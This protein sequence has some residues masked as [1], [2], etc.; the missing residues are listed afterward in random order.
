[1]KTVWKAEERSVKNFHCSEEGREAAALAEAASEGWEDR[2]WA[3]DRGGL[4]DRAHYAQRMWQAN[5]GLMKSGW[6]KRP[7]G[8]GENACGPVT[9]L[10]WGEK[11]SGKL[12]ISL[13]SLLELVLKVAK[14]CHCEEP[15][16][17][18][19][20]PRGWKTRAKIASRSLSWA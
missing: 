8:W 4:D 1:M 9:P 18:K 17:T 11:P 6:K 14:T 2:P 15:Q 20:S 3:A 10:G 7:V 13:S 5:E 12:F 19:Q 16:A